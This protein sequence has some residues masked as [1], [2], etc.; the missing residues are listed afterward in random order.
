MEEIYNPEKQKVF[1]GVQGYPRT[2]EEALLMGLQGKHHEEM[3]GMTI[4][5]FRVAQN[6][7]S[8]DDRL[9]NQHLLFFLLGSSETALAYWIRKGRLA[10]GEGGYYLEPDGLRECEKS[11][12]GENTEG[13]NASEE[14]VQDWVH[15]ML[16]GDGVATQ[17]FIITNQKV[18]NNIQP[19]PETFRMINA[20]RGQPK[21]RA[22]LLK[23]YDEKCVIT[24][25]GTVEAL[26]AAHI[27]PYIEERS[28][29]LSNG[30]LLR[31]DIHTLFDLFL[32]SID[33][34]QRVVVSPDC[35][36]SYRD[37]NGKQVSIPAEVL[38]NDEFRYALI[39]HYDKWRQKSG[40]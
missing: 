36:N 39:C 13:Y 8:I 11:L 3:R 33:P 38:N 40:C 21:F 30:L 35:L 7:I 18:T 1:Y 19:D 28:Y 25:C 24:D 22:E 16:L 10:E 37:L 12:N 32:I 5:A 31:A 29:Q 4:A 6:R 34:N 20:R 9:M 27:T 2:N 15:R 26:E 23:L 14:Q 17:K